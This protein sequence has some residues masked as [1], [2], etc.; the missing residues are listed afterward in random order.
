MI[1]VG[2]DIRLCKKKKK[3]LT[4]WKEQL[5]CVMISVNLDDNFAMVK[6]PVFSA[7]K[8]TFFKFVFQ[9]W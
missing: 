5:D 9:R 4:V 3:V 2:Q 7:I 8:A 1:Y 6:T